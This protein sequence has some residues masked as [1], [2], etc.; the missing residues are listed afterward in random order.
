MNTGACEQSPEEFE[1]E[2]ANA[3]HVGSTNEWNHCFSGRLLPPVYPQSSDQKVPLFV[4]KS[5]NA[6]MLNIPT[7]NNVR[8]LHNLHQWLSA[9]LML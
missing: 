7:Q 6:S 2:L 3:I 5:L 1:A 8:L 9:Y 4:L